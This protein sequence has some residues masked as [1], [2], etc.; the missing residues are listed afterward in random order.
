MHY[1][2]RD[3]ACDGFTSILNACCPRRGCPEGIITVYMCACQGHTTVRGRFTSLPHASSPCL[4]HP[5]RVHE[6]LMKCSMICMMLPTPDVR[7]SFRVHYN[8]LDGE[9]VSFGHII[10]SLYHTDATTLSNVCYSF[11]S[12]RRSGSSVRRVLPG[13]PVGHA[14]LGYLREPQEMFAGMDCTLS[15]RSKRVWLDGVIVSASN[16]GIKTRCKTRTRARRV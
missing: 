6:F 13:L 1:F 16:V 5:G 8:H 4:G 3:F 11:R 7:A 15:C 10:D 2:S 12:A 14:S 9:K